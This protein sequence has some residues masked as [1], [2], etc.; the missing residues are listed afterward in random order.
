LEEGALAA[1]LR[2]DG[3]TSD[4]QTLNFSDKI[5]MKLDLWGF[6]TNRDQ[7]EENA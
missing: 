6:T 4:K 1:N 7:K 2:G 5:P 3:M